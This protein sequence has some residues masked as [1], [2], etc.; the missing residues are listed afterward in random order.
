M[1]RV[2]VTGGA[3]YIGAALTAGLAEDGHDVVVVDNLSGEDSADCAPPGVRLLTEPC[4]AA[5]LVDRFPPGWR[6]ELVFHLAAAIEPDLSVADPARFFDYNVVQFIRL[7]D[8]LRAAS[9]RPPA[10]IFASSAAVYGDPGDG[11]VAETAPL[12][13]NNPYGETKR[14][15]ESMLAAYEAA[16]GAGWI[17]L[18]LFNVCGSV[19]PLGEGVRSRR[20]APAAV[21]AA[22]TGAPFALFGADHATKDGTA[23]RDY[24]YLGDVV[25]AFRLAMAAALD[26]ASA[27]VYNVGSGAGSSVG[28]L[29]AAVENRTGRRIALVRGD[30]RPGDASVLVA[31][32]RKI[33]R[34]LGWTARMR[35][36]DAM[37]D[38]LL[39]R[40]GAAAAH[41]E[42]PRD[43]GADQRMGSQGRQLVDTS[44]LRLPGDGVGDFID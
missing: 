10:V 37:V 30:R 7:L 12:A 19:G 43:A 13:P 14:I 1:T 3:G 9:A 22:M 17:A 34:E 5:D 24:V 18:R 35:C 42:H 29:V 21:R 16:Y 31:D 39:W 36:R 44:P 23:V 25:R 6:P 32:V 26:G 11:P 28:D 4:G 2:L 33:G 8:S 40:G 15:G 20:V 27:A 38:T 41:G